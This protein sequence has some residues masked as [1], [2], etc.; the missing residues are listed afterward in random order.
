MLSAAG[1]Q[2]SGRLVVTTPDVEAAREPGTTQA[3][4]EDIG[5]D[6]AIADDRVTPRFDCR[7]VEPARPVPS[8]RDDL[9]RGFDLSP[10]MLP[11]KYFY[12][13]RGSQLFDRICDTP[14]YYPTRAES[15]LLSAYA[16][17]LIGRVRPDHLIELGSGSSRKTRYLLSA[18][19]EQGLPLGYWPFDVCREMLQK[20]GGELVAEYPDLRVHALVGDYLGGLAHLP[21]PLGRRLFVFLGGT[22]GN[23]SELEAHHFLCDLRAQMQAG[24]HLL[25]GADRVKASDVLEAAYND[26]AGV[27]AAFNLN[28]LDVVNRELNADFDPAG[29]RH[30]AVFDPEAS[31]IEMYLVA[32]ARQQVRVEALGRSYR[33][34]RGDAILTEI[35]RKFTRRSLAAAL[36]RAGFAIEQHYEGGERL[37]SLVLARAATAARFA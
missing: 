23:F 20:A 2:S 3:Q 27:T 22:I 7:R 31:R 37:F 4:G 9:E 11:P 14:E 10:R 28:L 36:G 30:R 21:R 26:A 13:A 5:M 32:Q 19:R 12:D 15:F 33:F 25:L 34:D 29:F 24:D 1:G 35:S 6:F 17:R 16:E 8:L 18:A